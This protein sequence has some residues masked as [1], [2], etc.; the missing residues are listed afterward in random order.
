MGARQS[1]IFA[2]CVAPEFDDQKALSKVVLLLKHLCCA[3]PCIFGTFAPQDTCR[4][5][6]CLAL[7]MTSVTAALMCSEQS[8]GPRKQCS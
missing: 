2:R 5:S 8:E 3:I 7:L 1:A 6:G 4:A